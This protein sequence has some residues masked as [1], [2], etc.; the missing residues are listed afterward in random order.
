[1]NWILNAVTPKGLLNRAHAYKAAVD[2]NDNSDPDKGINAGLFNYPVLM[3]AD[4]LLFDADFVPVGSDQKQH[5]EMT[6]DIAGRFNN[7]YG[8]TLFFQSLL[9]LRNTIASWI[10]W[11]KDEQI[12]Q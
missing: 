9:F 8:K 6:R 4:I 3:A 1:M 12:L 5:I 11:K 7:T 10:R 2:L